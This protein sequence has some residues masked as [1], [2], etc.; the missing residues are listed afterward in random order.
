M[1]SWQNIIISPSTPILKAIEIIDAGAMKIGLVADDDYRLLGTVTDGDIRRGI[2]KGISLDDEVQMIMN[3]NPMTARSD[4]SHDTVLAIMKLKRLHQIPIVD[5]AGRVI[6]I[7]ILDDLLKSIPRNNWVVLMAGGLGSRLRPLTEDYPKPLLKVG[8]KPILETIMENFIEYGFRKFYLSV[9]YKADMIEG[10][11]GDGSRWGV[12]I[13]YLREDQKLGTAGA[14]G[15]LPE[16]TTEPLIIMNGDLLTKVNF[17][18]LLD[19]HKEQRAQATMCVRDY[20]FQ[21]PY[22]VVKVDKLRLI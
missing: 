16:M 12:E 6:D 8:N 21:I 20:D 11:F 15:L 2:L 18:Q 1:R 22:G 17:Q 19:F 7:K 13:R 9:N 5:E 4:E 14:L 10:H 3:S